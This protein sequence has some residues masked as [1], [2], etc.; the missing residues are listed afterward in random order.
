[1]GLV[2]ETGNKY[3]K[4]TVL[5]RVDPGDRVSRSAHWLCQCECGKT[6]IVRASTLRNGEASSCG[7]CHRPHL[8]EKTGFSRSYLYDTWSSMMSRCYNHNN[9]AFPS[10]GGRGIQVHVCW[11]SDPDNFYD[12]VEKNLGPRMEGHSLDR[13]NVYGNY[14]PGNLRWST[15]EEQVNNRRLILLSEEEYELVMRFRHGE[16]DSEDEAVCAGT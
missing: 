4:Y 8:I 1:M 10:Y 11:R 16:L 15:S 14:E 6:K 7:Q 5:K 2:D 3:G 13:I 9:P 12:W